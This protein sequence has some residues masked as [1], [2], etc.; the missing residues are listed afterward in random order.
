MGKK[1]KNADLAAE[2]WSDDD[3]VLSTVLAA[4]DFSEQIL[5]F[6]QL[7][8]VLKSLGTDGLGKAIKRRF[9][10]FRLFFKSHDVFSVEGSRVSLTDKGKDQVG[11]LRG[12]R[13]QRVGAA[14]QFALG[15]KF[16]AGQKARHGA[17]PEDAVPEGEQ[18]SLVEGDECVFWYNSE[19]GEVAQPTAAPPE[20]DASKEQRANNPRIQRMQEAEGANRVL[21]ERYAEN[22]ED[23]SPE[24]LERVKLLMKRNER[25]AV[26]KELKVERKKAKKERQAARKADSAKTLRLTPGLV[27]RPHA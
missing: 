10:G 26:K 20:S 3:N 13:S 22:P 5:D 7:D 25:I 23:L 16:E 21:M 18:W 6:N 11:M 19:T 14:V 12:N 2:K 15:N 27:Q 8:R 9:G 24:E 1:R 17:H 4:W